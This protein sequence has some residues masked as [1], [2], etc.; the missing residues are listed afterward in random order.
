MCT[1]YAPEIALKRTK[2]ALDL[3]GVPFGTCIQGK[4]LFK[5]QKLST[6]REGLRQKIVRRS[7]ISV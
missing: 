1:P 4:R 5:F 2:R 7:I 3:T 6:K